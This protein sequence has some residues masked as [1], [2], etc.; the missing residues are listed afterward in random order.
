MFHKHLLSR[1]RSCTA[2]VGVLDIYGFE[3]FQY[4]DFEQFCINLANE[5]LQQHFNSH[6]FKQEQVGRPPAAM[7]GVAGCV[8]VRANLHNVAFSPANLPGR[9]RARAD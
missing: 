6:V 4:N 9:V 3:Q 2:S 1:R 8:A 7:C 5:K